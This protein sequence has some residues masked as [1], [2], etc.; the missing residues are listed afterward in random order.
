M[1]D[2]I[3]GP[4]SEVEPW[5]NIVLH[6]PTH[7]LDATIQHA[8][9]AA[10]LNYTL[11]ELDSLRGGEGGGQVGKTNTHTRTRKVCSLFVTVTALW[12]STTVQAR[13]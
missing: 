11:P 10:R 13:G 7:T 9:L 12:C 5:G 2:W 3:P 8:R 1:R 6:P 4:T